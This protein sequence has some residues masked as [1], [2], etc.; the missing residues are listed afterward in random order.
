MTVYNTVQGDTWDWV[1][2]KVYSDE[3]HVG[4]LVTANPEHRNTALFSAGVELTI[5]ELPPPPI[6]SSLPPWRQGS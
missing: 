4:L 2:K 5:P 6:A 1:S 3:G